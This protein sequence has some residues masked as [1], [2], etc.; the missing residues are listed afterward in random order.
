MLRKFSLSIF[1]GLTL[2][3][4]ADDRS[5]L[6]NIK[7]MEADI[8]I[9]TERVGPFS[10][11]LF[12]PLMQLAR[13]QLDFE[14]REDAVDTLHRAQHI[15]HRNE[16]VYTTAQL[17]VIELLAGLALK[18]EE[19]DDANRQKFFAFFIMTHAFDHSA[20]EILSAHADLA[21]W[22]MHTGQPRRAR[23]I[24]DEAIEIAQTTDQDTLPFDI[25]A[26]QTRRLEGACC[27]PRLLVNALN[28][29]QQDARQETLIATYLEIADTLTLGG[30]TERAREYFELANNLSPLNSPPR[31]LVFRRNLQAP[32]SRQTESFTVNRITPLSAQERLRRMTRQEQLEHPSQEP[33]WFQFDPDRQHRGFE[34]RDLN[35]PYDREKRT[36]AVV[37]YPIL[38]SEDQLDQLLPFRWEK[39]KEELSITLSFTVTETGDLSDIEVVETNAPNKLNN[40]LSRVLR[41]TYYRPAFENGRPVATPGVTLKQTFTPRAPRDTTEP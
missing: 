6:E 8:D 33:Q 15:A 22:Y 1:L 2:V 3:A 7:A 16:G 13:L 38:F 10:E 25:L 18:G 5:D 30:K 36:Y 20:P 32:L 4:V 31:P 28:T 34:T 39:N 17:P 9:L 14:L 27:N 35:Q 29:K 11:E 21:D 12:N 23:N 26:N 37:G 19:F 40:L 24:I 41:K